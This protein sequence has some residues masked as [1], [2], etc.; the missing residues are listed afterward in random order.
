MTQIVNE[1]GKIRDWTKSGCILS[2]MVDDSDMTHTHRSIY[3]VKSFNSA[4][5]I[6]HPYKKFQIS[7]S[8]T[9]SLSSPLN[10]SQCVDFYCLDLNLGSGQTEVSCVQ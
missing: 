7:N 10:G 9:L 3:T 8:M 1:R 6:L 5:C 2:P 4:W